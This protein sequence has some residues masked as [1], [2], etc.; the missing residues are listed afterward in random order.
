MS[1]HTIHIII[2]PSSLLA[3]G[4]LND[5]SLLED[6]THYFAF[7][8]YAEQVQSVV[9]LLGSRGLEIKDGSLLS[10]RLALMEL[11]DKIVQKKVK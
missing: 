6:I 5:R 9:K 2:T 8:G 3:P 10:S 11:H 1:F 7:K 4:S